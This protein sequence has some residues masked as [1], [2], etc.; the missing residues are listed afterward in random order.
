MRLDRFSCSREYHL[1]KTADRVVLAVKRSGGT[2]VQL[3]GE[4]GGP[5]RVEWRSDY[6][7]LAKFLRWEAV[8]H[9]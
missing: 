2:R 6:R 4:R 8:E 9:V 3:I 1:K 5:W 7:Q